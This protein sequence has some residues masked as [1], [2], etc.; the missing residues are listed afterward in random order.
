MSNQKNKKKHLLAF[1]TKN[2][3]YTNYIFILKIV[4]RYYMYI[5]I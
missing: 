2:F 5:Y 3:D 4:Y 1:Y